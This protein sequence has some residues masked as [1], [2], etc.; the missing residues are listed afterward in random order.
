MRNQSCKVFWLKHW[1][2]G[3][4][5]DERNKAGKYVQYS[6]I[7]HNGKQHEKKSIY[8]CAKSFQL[9]PTLCNPTQPTRLLCPWDSP[10]KNT[11]VGCHSLLQGIFL[12]QGLNLGLLY[13]RQVLTTL[14]I[15]ITVHQIHTVN[16]IFFHKHVSFYLNRLAFVL[17]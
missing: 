12:I 11:G 5:E 4:A 1:N 15:A 13:C 6:V 10:G 3:K 2:C 16:F 14:C 8:V 9:C 7:N 17:T